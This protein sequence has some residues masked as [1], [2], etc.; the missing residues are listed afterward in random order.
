[1]EEVQKFPFFPYFD[2]FNLICVRK[3]NKYG[4]TF[5]SF[6]ILLWRRIEKSKRNFE[7]FLSVLR[8][9]IKN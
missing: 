7:S 4:S 9:F 6:D 3:A 8:N 5:V 1:M 2:S